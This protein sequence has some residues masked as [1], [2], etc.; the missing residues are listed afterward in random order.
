[1]VIKSGIYK[2]ISKIKPHMFYIGSA[3]NIKNRFN[4]HKG[5]LKRNRHSNQILQNHVNIYGIE[6][7]EFL[8]L[9]YVDNLNNLLNKEQY[10]FDTLLPT[11]N[12]L[13]IAGSSLG[14]TCSKETK[15]KMSENSSKYWLSR[16]FSEE[17]KENISKGRTGIKANIPEESKQRKSDKLKGNKNA[18]GLVLTEN[19]K[20][21]ISKTHKGKTVS[22]ET[23]KKL[24]ESRIDKCTVSI[25]QFSLEGE[26]I[27][28]WNSMINAKKHL[29]FK[30]NHISECCSGKIKTAHGFIWKYKTIV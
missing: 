16:P 30:S 11:F 7:L 6:D 20:A 27:Q 23:R 1:M 22:S 12:I 29:N 9:E 24:S 8:I 25:L 2:I 4:R 26:F 28:E 13:K 19:H 10:Y 15:I 3:V 5:D 14:S 18:A 17:H 21:A